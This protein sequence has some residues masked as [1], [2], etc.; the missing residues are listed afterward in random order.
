[1]ENRQ[2]TIESEP[3]LVK[4]SMILGF[5]GWM[6]GGDVSTGTVQYLVNRLGATRFA[7]IKPGGFYL[8]NF[9][10]T[11]EYSALFRPHANIQGGLIRQFDEPTNDFY[12]DAINNLILFIGK[13]PNL[14]WSD[15][16]EAIFTVCQ[17]YGVERMVFIG[18]VSGLTPHTREP[19]FSCVISDER[20]KNRL[21][22]MPIVLTDYSGPASIITYLSVEAQKR[23]IEMLSLVA[24]IPAYL[25]GYNPRCVEA[26][27]RCIS[28]IVGLHVEV[29]DLREL[30]DEFEKK[31]NEVLQ[32]QPDLLDKIQK[33]E[34]DYDDQVFNTDLGDLRDWLKQQGIRLE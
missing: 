15:Y 18:S 23:G 24:E 7:R 20:I 11:M 26:S 29:T 12:S 32:S 27:V 2:L 1:M 25:Q 34:T 10:G 16:A 9:P 8:Y 22:G 5:T 4:P 28:G 31:V 33:L 17:R 19:R 13:E 6:D 14:A 30:G 3:S 21:E